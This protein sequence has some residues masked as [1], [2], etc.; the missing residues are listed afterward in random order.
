MV[1]GTAL[2]EHALGFFA[3]QKLVQSA[4]APAGDL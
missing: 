3:A 2:G 1:T 4:T